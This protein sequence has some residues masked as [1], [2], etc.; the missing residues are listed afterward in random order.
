MSEIASNKEQAKVGKSSKGA[1]KGERRGG[2]IKGTP[3]KRTQDLIDL[4]QEKYPDFDPILSLIDIS[5]NDDTPL[6]IKVTCLKEV[7]KYIHP[8]RKA[9]E[10][11]TKGN[12][13]SMAEFMLG[14]EKVAK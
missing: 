3:N 4:I 2:R 12:N 5:L 7:A 10:V 8:Q 14:L 13:M 9:V 1:K 11:S 6:D